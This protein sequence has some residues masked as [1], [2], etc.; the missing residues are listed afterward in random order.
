MSAA[1]KLCLP[2][3]P[4]Y[5]MP[6]ANFEYG[7]NFAS[8]GSGITN[9]NSNISVTLSNQLRQFAALRSLQAPHKL[10]PET[11]QGAL[12]IISSRSND[13]L[14][15]TAGQTDYTALIKGMLKRLAGD[16]Q[17]LYGKG[18]RKILVFEVPPLGCAPATLASYEG[19]ENGGCISSVNA[20]VK[21]YNL[22][23][24][25][26]LAG[27][28]AALPRAT[29]LLAR[30]QD[31]VT[32]AVGNPSKHGKSQRALWLEPFWCFAGA[33]QLGSLLKAVSVCMC[34]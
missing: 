28:R 1:I 33:R 24:N 14:A 21:S 16:I 15:T 27:L 7:A 20:V 17:A 18:A 6:Y 2:V 3:A 8:G 5:L 31:F 26:T 22:P 11:F 23:L 9:V 32:A 13:L 29:I 10:Q 4:P 19:T 34:E 30:V 25:E 12:Y